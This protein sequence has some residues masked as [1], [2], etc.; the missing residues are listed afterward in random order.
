MIVVIAVLTGARIAPLIRIA[1]RPA[2]AHLMAIVVGPTVLVS[3][4]FVGSVT[5]T[6]PL[7]VGGI[8]NTVGI[9]HIYSAIVATR[10]AGMI[11]FAG[12][13]LLAITPLSFSAGFPA[14]ATAVVIGTVA[15]VAAV[16]SAG[17][18]C[19]AYIGLAAFPIAISRTEAAAL[20][21][22]AVVDAIG[23]GCI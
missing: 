12:H 14:L 3:E 18:V 20:P 7:L 5:T 22:A 9:R 23:V 21:T 13:T 11:L 19:A 17:V 15:L 16:R 1:G 8:L 10:T 4:A 6:A 2:V